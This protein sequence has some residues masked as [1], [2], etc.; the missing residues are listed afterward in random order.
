MI[1]KLKKITLQAIAGANCATILLMLLVGYS[2]HI[3]PTY[4]PMLSNVGLLFPAFIVINA[5]FLLFWVI[6]KLKGAVIPFVGYILCYGPMRTYIP[7]NLPVDP[8][9]GAIKVLS[10]NTEGYHNMRSDVA[11]FSDDTIASYILHSGADI[12][13]VQE[14]THVLD[15]DS[16]FRKRYPYI[17]E[18]KKGD[19]SNLVAV[20][21]RYPIRRSQVIDFLSAG[22]ISAAFYLDV[23]GQDV[24]VINN[25]LETNSLDNSDKNGFGNLIKGSLDKE[26]ARS[27]STRLID[28]LALASKKRAPQAEAVA[29][30]I[31]NHS[32]GY[33]II[34]CGDFNENPLGYAHTRIGKG[35]TDC[36]AATGTGIGRSFNQNYMYVRID[37]MFCSPDIKPYA[38]TVDN[39][40]KASD[41]Y[42]IYCWFK[43]GKKI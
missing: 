19:G 39:R 43:F 33:R 9:V 29:R 4:H 41:H 2:G 24:L 11:T 28:K 30:Y 20:Y 7:F 21:S 22:N 8:P 10:F 34:V 25:H 16:T 37:H 35:L 6:V 3:N 32:S 15:F 1:A 26:M 17:K 42:P 5:A 31:A 14:G 27:E 13:C 40:I 18:E 38:C 12:V 23:N 36:Y